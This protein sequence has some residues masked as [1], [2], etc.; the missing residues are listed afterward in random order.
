[1]KK[2]ILAAALL[3]LVIAGLTFTWGPARNNEPEPV[4][5]PEEIIELPEPD[6]GDEI[7]EDD[8]SIEKALANRRSIREYTDEPLPLEKISQLLWA[9]QGITDEPRGFRTAPSAG[10]LYPLETYLIINEV[11]T[12]EPGVYRFDPEDETLELHMAGDFASELA[13]A[14]LGQAW[15]REAPVNILFGAVYERIE[16]RYGERAERYTDMEIGHAAQNIY[17]QCE[18]LGLGTVS[19]GAFDED[20][21]TSLLELPDD[22]V[23]RLLMP[24]GVTE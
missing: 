19:V 3:I 12:L 6:R 7:M 9:A 20:Q 17:L 24:V 11:E 14:A 10:A 21:T 16:P 1:M 23:P 4:N 2:Y 5:S 18:S 22:V 15:V 8:V 13:A